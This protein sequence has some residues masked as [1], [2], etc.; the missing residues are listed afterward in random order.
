MMVN[1][2]KQ[3]L[4]VRLPKIPNVDED[5][6]A[7]GY[8]TDHGFVFSLINEKSI[9]LKPLRCLPFPKDEGYESQ[10]EIEILGIIK[11][12]PEP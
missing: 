6:F 3:L 4:L 12:L 9:H 8:Y 5:F 10:N 11:N 7:I 1:L 2:M